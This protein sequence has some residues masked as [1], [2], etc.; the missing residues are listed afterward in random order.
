MRHT[1]CSHLA[2]VANDP[3]PGGGCPQCIAAGDTWFHLRFC[4]ACGA[5]G[6]CEQ[7]KN[8]HARKHWESTEH[9]VIRSM[10]PEEMWAWCYPDEEAVEV[11]GEETWR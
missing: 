9:P 10:E 6:C 11:A 2:A 1:Q 8:Q 5:V 7:S 4:V 3:K